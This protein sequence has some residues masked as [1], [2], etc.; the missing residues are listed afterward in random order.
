MII[1]ILV[2][3]VCIYGAYHIINKQKNN[4]TEHYTSFNTIYNQEQFRFDCLS[5]PSKLC[6]YCIYIPER[7]NYIRNLFMQ[8]NQQN[9]CFFRGFEP[10]Q[11]SDETYSSLS[12][13]NYIFNK[14]Y[15]KKSKLCV[16]LSYMMCIFHAIQHNNEYVFIFEDD[17]YFTEPYEELY[18]VYMDFVKLDY[19]VCFVGY[20]KCKN[21]NKI[22]D[23]SSR[24]TLLPKKQEILCKHA[25]IY[26]TSYLK[27]IWFDLLPLYDHSDRV[28]LKCHHKYNAKLCI[29]NKPFVFQDRETFKSRNYNPGKQSLY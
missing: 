27:K 13:I 23:S 7:E 10:S 25:M 18:R 16:H 9:I 15:K 12:S 28:F 2:L 1:I 24:L 3:C 29:V 26:K 8:F 17:I 19:D 5:S 6:T 11:L 20:C 21:C 4:T 22:L 14:M